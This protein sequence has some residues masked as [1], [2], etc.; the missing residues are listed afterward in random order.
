MSDSQAKPTGGESEGTVPEAVVG[1]LSRY[2]RELQ[3]LIQSGRERTSS[4]QLGKRLNVSPAQ[5]RKDLAF[6]GNFGYPG[7]GYRCDELMHRIRSI[8]GTDKD[9]RVALVGVG[10]LGRALLG[11]RGF[12]EQGFRI[13]AA[14]DADDCKIGT[15][16]EGLSIGP[17]SSL[18]ERV[19]QLDIRLGIIAVPAAAAQAVADQLA[20]SGIEGILNFAPV[21]VVLPSNVRQVSVNLAIQLEQ[22]SFDVLHRRET[23]DF[24]SDD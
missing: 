4:G 11:Y 2:L 13:L 19:R 21:T 1:R 3:V 23:Q 7:I 12:Q 8:L 14:F 10:N 6:F 20:S 16:V 24:R 18:A 17:L 22:L 9:W 5:V 15:I